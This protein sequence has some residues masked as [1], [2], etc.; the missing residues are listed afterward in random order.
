[1]NVKYKIIDRKGQKR[2]DKTIKK[3]NEKTEKKER[4][5]CYGRT[6]IR[7]QNAAEKGRRASV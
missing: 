4:S 7:L 2:Y 5:F 6:D 1:M 3:S